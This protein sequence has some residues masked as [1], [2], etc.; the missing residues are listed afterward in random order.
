MDPVRRMLLQA[1][2]CLP[3]LGWLSEGE[4]KTVEPVVDP[5]IYKPVLPFSSEKLRS[6]YAAMIWSEHCFRTRSTLWQAR[7]EFCGRQLDRAPTVA[8]Y[9]SDLLVYGNSFIKAGDDRYIGMAYHERRYDPLKMM[10]APN[11]DIP[12][13]SFV[14]PTLVST[15]QTVRCYHWRFDDYQKVPVQQQTAKILNN[16]HWGLPPLAL[17]GEEKLLELLELLKTFQAAE[18]KKAL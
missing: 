6:V 13:Y 10:I 12:R 17:L 14:L 15:L 16:K 7:E 1:I 11:F 3:G 18:T 9:W 2:A 5:Y 4:A 8:T